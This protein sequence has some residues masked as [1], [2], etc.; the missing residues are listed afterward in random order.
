M[1]APLSSLMKVL[2]RCRFRGELLCFTLLQFVPLRRGRQL[3][4]VHRVHGV[5][6]AVRVLGREVSTLGR[7]EAA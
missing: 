6:A 3:V 2:A 4:R 1:I 5:G 7:R